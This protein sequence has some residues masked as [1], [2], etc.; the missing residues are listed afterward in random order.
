M[1]SRDILIRPVITEKS[2]HMMAE[3]KYVFKVPE[4]ASKTDVKT[5][6]EEIF[7]VKVKSVNT[8]KVPGK[9]RR[10]GR[11]AGRKPSWKKAVVTLEPG[12]KISLFEGM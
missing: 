11:F 12:Q 9:P 5:A 4:K 8:M 10:M 6:V 7:K 2:S 1:D 3:D